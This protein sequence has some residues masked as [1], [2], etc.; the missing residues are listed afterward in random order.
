[1][2]LHNVRESLKQVLK[3]QRLSRHA[4]ARKHEIG[5]SWLDKFAQGQIDNPRF[6]SLKRLEEAIKSESEAA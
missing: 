6:N 2:D 5:P 1:M 4:F 3:A